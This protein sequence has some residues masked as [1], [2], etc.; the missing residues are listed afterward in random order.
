MCYMSRQSSLNTG[1]YPRTTQPVVSVST[2]STEQ[3]TTDG[4]VAVANVMDSTSSKIHY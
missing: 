1:D 4:Q 2:D 3:H